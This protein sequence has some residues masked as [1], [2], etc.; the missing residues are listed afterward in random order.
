MAIFDEL[1]SVASTLRE[2]DKIE[3]YQQI[4]DVQEKLLEMQKKIFDL[5]QENMNL[6]AEILQKK[7]L[8]HVSEVYYAEDDQSQQKPLCANCYDAKGK[9]IHLVS[10]WQEDKRMCPTCKGA[11][12]IL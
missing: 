9:L 6:K 3:Q 11:Y 1:K 2:A 12:K 10:S 7:A 4:L 8:V 5:E